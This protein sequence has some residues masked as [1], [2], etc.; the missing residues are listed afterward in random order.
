MKVLHLYVHPDHAHSHANRRLRDQLSSELTDAGHQVTLHDL[1]HQYPDGFISIAPERALVEQHDALLV[2]HPM[3][4]FNVPS[5]FKEWLDRVLTS[6]WA[7]GSAYALAD[8]LWLQVVT[9]G[10]SPG[11]Y[12][13]GN[14]RA[15]IATLMKPFEITARYCRM[16][17]L[18]PVAL[19]DADSAS[20]QAIT[21]C[22][23]SVVTTMSTTM[24]THPQTLDT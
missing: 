6:D 11:D 5:L 22:A 15:S 23:Q 18:S 12:V 8:K 24:R 2:Q 17:W 9:T 14:D 7:F 13:E 19:F 20:P 16:R 10:G 1:Y 3:Y 4:W 21:E